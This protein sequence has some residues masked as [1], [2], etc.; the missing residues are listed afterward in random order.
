LRQLF[1]FSLEL[2]PAYRDLFHQ[3][4]GRVLAQ[5]GEFFDAK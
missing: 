3:F 1:Q 4:V 5:R 2:R